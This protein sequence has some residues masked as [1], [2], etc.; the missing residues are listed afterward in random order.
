MVEIRTQKTIFNRI[1]A[2]KIRF[3]SEN[4][5]AKYFSHELKVVLDFSAGNCEY[6]SL[7]K[8]IEGLN[9]NLTHNWQSNI[10]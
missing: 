8:L 1:L 10:D 6:A 5:L 7:Q 2:K 4:L 9:L 3:K